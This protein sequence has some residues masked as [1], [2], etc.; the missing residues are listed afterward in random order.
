MNPVPENGVSPFRLK[1][2]WY[3]LLFVKG[4][5]R[6]RHFLQ[7]IY[8]FF[9]PILHPLLTGN[10]QLVLWIFEYVSVLFCLFV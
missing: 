7:T 5:E 9:I 1:I 6:F 8:L 3:V 4:C 10:H 2:G